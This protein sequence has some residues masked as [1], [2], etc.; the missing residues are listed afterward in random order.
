MGLA[1]KIKHFS[2]FAMA[3]IFLV[4]VTPLLAPSA[5]AASQKNTVK[6]VKAKPAKKVLKSK[7]RATSRAAKFSTG[8]PNER[9]AEIVVD[10]TNGRVLEQVNADAQRYPASLTK[11]MTLYLTFDA[12][13]KKKLFLTD[14][15]PVSAKAARQPETNIDLQSGDSISVEDCILSIV[16]RSA[17]DSAMVLAEGVGKTEWN[18]AQLM[19]AKARQLGMSNTIFRNPN[20]LPDAGQFTSARDMAKLGIALRRDFPQYF[21]Y[22]KIQEFSYDGKIYP[23]HNR[24]IGRFDGVDGIKTGYINASGFNLVT[25]VKRDGKSIVAVI[26]GGTSGASRDNQMVALLE[27][28]FNQFAAQD[29]SAER[30]MVEAEAEEDARPKLSENPTLVQGNLKAVKEPQIAAI[31]NGTN[32]QTAASA[33]DEA[34]DAVEEA[35]GNVSEAKNGQAPANG[36]TLRAAEGPAASRAAGGVLSTSAARSPAFLSGANTAQNISAANAQRSTT[37]NAER[38]SLSSTAVQ[39][40]AASPGAE[41]AP[42]STLGAER[43]PSFSSAAQRLPPANTLQLPEALR[44]KGWGI[45]IGAY[46]GAS[47]AQKAAARAQTLAAPELAAAVPDIAPG[48][49]GTP[50]RAR[51]ASLSEK[52]AKDACRKLL[53]AKN[54]CFIYKSVGAL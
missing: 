39:R 13:K 32:G 43:A 30:K 10:A 38:A 17:N 28:T 1:G 8:L 47:E 4:S 19:T 33:E 6:V 20:G 12:L 2:I 26:M 36:R 5:Q 53:A 16:V 15:L 45:Q 9:F 44:S 40:A 51:L 35:Q 37:L 41:S 14:R 34:E 21:P 18:F 50:Y 49:A 7:R 23:G 54:S 24:V 25:S 3:A 31:L 52:Q 11:M 22:F 46:A 29:R 27:R 42:V 48:S